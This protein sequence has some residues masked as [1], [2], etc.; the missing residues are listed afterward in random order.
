[1]SKVELNVAPT[2]MSQE[3][4][5]PATQPIASSSVVT[6]PLPSKVEPLQQPEPSHQV[7]QSRQVEQPIPVSTD[8][9]QKL[10]R[11]A[12]KSLRGQ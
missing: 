5:L 4:N 8:E 9:M 2:I 10:V 6:A 7:E 12:G 11:A 3:H 1:V